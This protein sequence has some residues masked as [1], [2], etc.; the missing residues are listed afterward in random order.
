MLLCML[1]MLEISVRMNRQTVPLA[2]RKSIWNAGYVAFWQWHDLFS[3]IY[4][5]L[6]FAGII[7]IL[8]FV[9]YGLFKFEIYIQILG[10][11][12]FVLEASFGWS[13][14]LKNFNRKSTAGMRYD[15]EREQF[16]EY[17]RY[18]K[19]LETE[20]DLE[21]NS[22]KKKL[23]EL[24]GSNRRLTSELEN[25][26]KRYE[27]ER[28][29]FLSTESTL[30]TKL[31]AT[32]NNYKDLK[33]KLRRVEQ[34]NDDLE[35]RERIQAQELVDWANRYEKCLERCAILEAG[36]FNGEE[37]MDHNGASQEKSP[38]VLTDRT[39]ILKRSIM[40]SSH[41]S[42]PTTIT[43]KDMEISSLP[44][45]NH[46]IEATCNGFHNAVNSP[47]K[48]PMLTLSPKTK[49]RPSSAIVT[50]LFRKIE[51]V[52]K[53]VDPNKYIIHRTPNRK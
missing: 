24:E 2:Q 45:S 8:T 18:S 33:E 28:Q 31:T 38:D 26:K 21:L 47:K 11:I 19:E 3:F 6:L 7:A 39:N 4:A 37:E 30:R 9:F 46:S 23:A 34:F 43:H 5:L 40:N 12:P 51:E 49:E 29:E 1:A 22:Y 20:L 14:L 53:Q 44:N 35:R 25:L 41:I 42:T 48:T 13:Q 27:T 10:S 36:V 15:Q 17:Q 16:L 52:E 50:S 32:E